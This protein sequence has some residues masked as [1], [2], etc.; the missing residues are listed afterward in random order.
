MKKLLV[1]TAFASIA[2][3]VAMC[4]MPAVAEEIYLGTI[5]AGLLSDAGVSAVNN[6]N[7]SVPFAVPRSGKISIQCDATTN[8]IVVSE[9]GTAASSSNGVLVSSNVLFPTSTPPGYGATSY[10]SVIPSTGRTICKVFSRRGN[11]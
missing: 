6:Q 7:T 5:D 3:I 4:S 1:I 8:Y 11:E 10:V 9:N 2:A